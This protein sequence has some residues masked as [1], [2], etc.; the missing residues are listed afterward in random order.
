MTNTEEKQDNKNL[1][2]G[3]VMPISAIEGC[4][5]NHWL[6]VKTILK[7]AI[8]S[9]GYEADIVSNAEDIGI[10]Q[11]RIVQNLY[12]KDIIVCD[13][14]CKN[15]NVMFE[16][17]MR[18]A[19]DKPTI[20]VV[21]DM[22]GFSFDTSPIE[23]LVYPRDLRY[24]K[25]VEF[26]KKLK[27]KIL[28]TIKKYEEDPSYSPFLKSFGEFKVATI[29]H[30]E[31]SI[32]DVVLQKI[33]DIQQT[34]NRLSHP[35]RNLEPKRIFE[36]NNYKDERINTLVRTYIDKYINDAGIQE[37]ILYENNNNE[38]L[39]LQEYLEKKEFL[40]RLCGSEQRLQK[41]IDDNLYPF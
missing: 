19:F 33:D 22:T 34:I 31:G 36:E 25:I 1:T 20:I 8:K 4:P 26:K 15:A 37:N 32:N 35:T 14:S 17:G 40:R 13:V 27:D 39:N 18:L 6:E 5:E 29:E 38:R 3:I 23:H 12:D 2:C 28:G 7:E 21:D 30:K 24:S 16:L 11:T 41:A 9:A 10:I